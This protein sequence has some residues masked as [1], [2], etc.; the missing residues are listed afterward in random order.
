MN[1]PQTFDT[2]FNKP[3]HTLREQNVAAS[4]LAD[5]LN[6]GKLTHK[7]AACNTTDEGIKRKK[8]LDIQAEA[9]RLKDDTGW[10]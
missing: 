6:K 10:L 7:T 2:S 9:Q 8:R 1:S 3:H 5:E 4:L